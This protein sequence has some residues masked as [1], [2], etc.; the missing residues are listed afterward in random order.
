M[1]SNTL[2]IYALY[3]EHPVICTDSRNLAP[4]SLFFALKGANFNG[5]AFALFALTHGAAYAVTDEAIDDI[6]ESMAS[7]VIKVPDVLRCLQDLARH[8]RLQLSIPVI[9]ITGSNGKTTSKELIASVLG[10]RF[11]TFATA[12]NLNN[13]IGVPLSILSVG[14]TVEVAI[15][16]MGA[17][18]QHEIE[19]LCTI[20]QPGL[21]FVTNVG[22]AHLEGFGGF[23]GVKKGKKELYDWLSG[24]RGLAFV[25]AGSA[26]LVEMSQGVERRVFYGKDALFTVSGNE[27]ANADSPFLSLEW[28]YVQDSGRSYPVKTGLTGSY[29][30]ENALAAVLVGLHL[31]LTAAEINAGLAAYEPRNNRSQFTEGSRNKLL[32]DHY[33]ANPTSMAASIDN[34]AKLSALAKMLILGDMFELGEETRAEHGRVLHRL[35]EFDRGSRFMLI[36][37]AF[38]QF[39]GEKANDDRFRFFSTTPEAYD[40][41]MDE[42]PA[43]YL[44]M[45]KGSHGMQLEKLVPLL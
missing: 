6:P 44:I 13:H 21:G 11:K 43:G 29:N 8:H 34:F 36:G 14:P 19:F 30:L 16:E 35:E 40:F 39:K 24:V 5:N 10:Q 37:P 27:V 38:G 41:L 1:N 3:L 20:S 18:H 2:S 7:R 4:G 26:D 15:I 25:Q 17:N 31:G 42:S 45:V 12:G 33:N 28:R 23:E 9:G 32:L 22:L